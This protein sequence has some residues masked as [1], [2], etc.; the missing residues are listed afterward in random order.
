MD[1]LVVVP[2]SRAAANQRSGRAGRTG[3]GKCYRLYTEA[4]FQNEM[5]PNTVP[6]I[7][8]TNLANTV[9]TLKAMGINDLLHFDFMDP[10]PAQTL[11]TAMEQ[12]Y[13]LGALEEEG[14][15]TRVGRKMAEFPLEPQLSK[16][17][18]GSVEMGCS[19]EVLTIVAM[20]SVQNIFYRPKDKQS[21]ADQKKARFH[22][23]EGDHLTLLTVYNAW[24]NSNYSNAWCFDN[25]VQSRSLKRAQDVRKQLVGI[26]DRYHNDIISCGRDY[27]LV[28]KALASGFFR[29][30]AK[31]DP[32]EGYKTLVEGTPVYIHPSSALFQ[33]NPEWVIYH[34][35]VMTTR[36]YMREVTSIEP[37]WLIEV[38]P[39]YFKVVDPRALSKRKRAEKIEPLY[40]KHQQKDEWRISKM[41]RT[42]HTTQT[43]SSG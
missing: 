11:I 29:N 36:E 5:L 1:S 27:V 40:D 7:Q 20:L 39:A 8:R 33:R 22:Q 10:P 21:V 14:F 26:M 43:F 4:A 2:I 24:K 41:R 16:F 30:T 15:L 28:R 31:K 32:Q 12:L 38:A 42:F 17:L 13:T 19:E 25:Y 34:E 18:I 23:P 3:P 6:E 37:K 9:L 35:L